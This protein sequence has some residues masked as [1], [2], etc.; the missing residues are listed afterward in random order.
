MKTLIVLAMLAT[1]FVS[2][3]KPAAVVPDPRLAVLEARLAVLETNSVAQQKAMDDYFGMFREVSTNLQ[4]TAIILPE[5][6]RRILSLEDWRM[7]FAGR[8]V[9][10]RLDPATGL[11]VG[12]NPKDYSQGLIDPLTGIPMPNLK[13]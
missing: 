11:P 9:K 5:L 4:I 3:C 10:V 7:A 8:P 13:R 2:G 12:A 1:V 6:H